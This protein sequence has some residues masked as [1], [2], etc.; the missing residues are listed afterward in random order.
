MTTTEILAI[1]CGA[2]LGY[3]LVAVLWPLLRNRDGARAAP[4]LFDAE[5]EW[6][7]VLG[8]DRYA[9]R[10]AIEAAYRA[11][12]AEH[13]PETVAHLGPEARSRAQRRIAQLDRAHAAALQE[14]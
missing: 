13:L 11:K 5:P 7:E 9:S 4:S 3:W 12:R 8:V 14:M 2:A 6:P 10:E 1:V